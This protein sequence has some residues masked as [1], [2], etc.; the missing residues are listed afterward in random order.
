MCSPLTLIS[1]CKCGPVEFPVEPTVAIISPASTFCPAVTYIL[2]VWAYQVSTPLPW[3]IFTKLPY[4]PS[5]FADI[6]VPAA[7][8]FISVPDFAAISNPVWF[9]FLILLLTP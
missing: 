4:E 7:T 3:S 2:L 6:T 9:D 5:Y 1:K 8:T